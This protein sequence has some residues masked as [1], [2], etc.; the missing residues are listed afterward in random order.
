MLSSHGCHDTIGYSPHDGELRSIW[1]SNTHMETHASLFQT[2]SYLRARYSF[3]PCK[4]VSP[5]YEW[6][7]CRPMIAH[8]LGSGYVNRT[9]LTRNLSFPTKSSKNHVRGGKLTSM[10][11][12]AHQDTAQLVPSCVRESTKA[13]SATSVVIRSCWSATVAM[14][15]PMLLNGGQTDLTAPD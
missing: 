2:Q 14:A 11:G 8:A 4:L 1:A 7:L 12:R 3:R 13:V 5:R 6:L 15:V 10:R 9:Q